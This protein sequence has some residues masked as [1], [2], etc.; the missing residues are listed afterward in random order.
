MSTKLA[1]RVL[2]RT[3][4]PPKLPVTSNIIQPST[5]DGAAQPS[6]GRGDSHMLGAQRQDPSK[7]SNTASFLV[8]AY[9]CLHGATEVRSAACAPAAALTGGFLQPSLQA[10]Q[11]NSVRAAPPVLRF[12]PRGVGTARTPRRSQVTVQ[13]E[14][15]TLCLV[16]QQSDVHRSKGVQVVRKA[17][18]RR[19]SF[20]EPS[21]FLKQEP[22]HLKRTTKAAALVLNF[23]IQ[24]N[25]RRLVKD[26]CATGLCKQLTSNMAE[27]QSIS[28]KDKNTRGTKATIVAPQ[29]KT[30][31]LQQGLALPYGNCL[32]S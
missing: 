28:R 24:A 9:Q 21:L 4:L 7:Q 12:P 19:Q 3:K 2:H 29:R 1:F 31:L 23:T 27:Q 30:A 22:H 6:T 25:V 20:R 5:S 11:A 32:F 18:C 16:I 8:S 17:C 15:R 14:Q 26:F 10:A 13:V